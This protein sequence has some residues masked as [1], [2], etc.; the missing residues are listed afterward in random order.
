MEI[1]LFLKCYISKKKYQKLGSEVL[2][3]EDDTHFIEIYEAFLHIIK[4]SPKLLLEYLQ[5][6]IQKHEQ[7]D[8]QLF[9]DVF[10]GENESLNQMIRGYMVKHTNQ[11]SYLFRNYCHDRYEHYHVLLP[12]SF[13]EKDGNLTTGDS[14][15]FPVLCFPCQKKVSVLDLDGHLAPKFKEL[16]YLETAIK[17]LVNYRIQHPEFT[18][19]QC[20]ENLINE[21]KPKVYHL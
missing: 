7:N 12:T 1:A 9:E 16:P 15:S 11:Q 19:K 8:Y 13:N 6:Y 3:I 18:Q 2:K 20:L 17:Y 10:V 4:F 5:F 21:G 14:T